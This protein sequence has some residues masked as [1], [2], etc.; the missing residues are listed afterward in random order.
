MVVDG[1]RGFLIEHVRAVWMWIVIVI[2]DCFKRIKISGCAGGLPAILIVPWKTL[3]Q[4]VMPG[5]T[6]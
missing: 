4:L 2:A 3:F 5:G 6:R 1:D